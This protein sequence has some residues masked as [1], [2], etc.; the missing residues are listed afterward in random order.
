[1][2]DR[3]SLS[4]QST[5]PVRVLMMKNDKKKDENDNKM[6]KRREIIREITKAVVENC[7]AFA[8]RTRVF[9]RGISVRSALLELKGSTRG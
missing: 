3:R 2:S 1:M 7:T 5:Q 9:C 8:A 4:M 6:I